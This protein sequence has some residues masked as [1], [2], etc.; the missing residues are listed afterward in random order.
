[1]RLVRPARRRWVEG[2]CRVQ[3]KRSITMR[4]CISAF[5]FSSASVSRRSP[6][7][8]RMQSSS[9]WLLFTSMSTPHRCAPPALRAGRM[10]RSGHPEGDNDIVEQYNNPKELV[11]PRAACR[12]KAAPVVRERL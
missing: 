2:E 1:D 8:P 6:N 5:L 10:D 4:G 12:R 3:L 7:L 11:S 9:A